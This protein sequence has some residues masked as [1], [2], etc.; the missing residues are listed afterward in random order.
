MFEVR[1]CDLAR[2]CVFGTINKFKINWTTTKTNENLIIKLSNSL[3]FIPLTQK[4]IN[5]FF[6]S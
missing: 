2:S 3:F 5:S 6:S 4:I 1:I